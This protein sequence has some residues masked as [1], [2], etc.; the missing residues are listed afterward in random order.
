MPRVNEGLEITAE[1]QRNLVQNLGVEGTKGRTL[2]LERL[3]GALEAETDPAFTSMGE[4]IRTDLPSQLDG[5][6]LEVALSDIATKLGQL[7]EVRDAGVPDEPTGGYSDIVE[8][9]RRVYDHFEDVGFFE[10]V[11]ENLP[12]FT[13]E[14]IA[15]TARELV[16]ADPLK[17]ALGDIGF[18]EREKVALLM[19][20]VNNNTRL[21][22]WVPTNEIPTD[23]VEFDVSVVPPL[24]Q[25]A[26]GGALLWI[27]NLDQ[28]LWQNEVLITE[29]V[30]DDAVWHVKAMLGGLYAVV[31]AA[32]DVAGEGTLSDGQLTAALTAGSAID[33][34]SQEELMKDV[35]YITDEMRAPRG[36]R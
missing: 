17:A 21:A 24:H 11:E 35:Y 34:I 10:T 16:F 4:S 33:I 6:M 23:E 14:H 29:E 9:G 30:L 18:T 26:V 15:H 28:H 5:E 19:S 8:P 12:R 27:D 22:R 36:V 25:R 31:M 3:S 2:T 32:N 13:P 1:D 20:V 7:S